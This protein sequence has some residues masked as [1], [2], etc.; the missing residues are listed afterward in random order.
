MNSI[1]EIVEKSFSKI[2]LVKFHCPNCNAE[3]YL[4]TTP[5]TLVCPNPNCECIWAP[6]SSKGKYEMGI[7]V[8]FLQSKD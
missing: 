8:T 2:E 7:K 6:K 4:P 5:G 3:F 1:K